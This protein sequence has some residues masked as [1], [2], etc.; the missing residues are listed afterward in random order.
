MRTFIRL[1]EKQRK[2]KKT[3]PEVVELKKQVEERLNRK[4]KT[5]KDFDFLR[6]TIWDSNKEII[7]STTL[8]RL[9]GYISGAD[10]TRTDT[11]D[12]L[13]RL[14]GCKDWDDFLE[15]I[16]TSGASE[17]IH[18]FHISTDGMQAG[19]RLR[20]SWRPDR[21]CLFRYL[22]NAIFI[23]EESVN[24]KLQAGDTFCASLFILNEP[25]YLSNLI[26]GDNPPVPYVVG[27]KDGICELELVPAQR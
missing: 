21:H 3:S 15:V 1:I 5:P 16:N 24:S 9:W 4:M 25:L 19:D 27:N 10:Q 14:L 2:M 12:I 22:G 20:V 13:S 6:S 11:L 26:H 7:S 18:S 8:K 23:V 17:F